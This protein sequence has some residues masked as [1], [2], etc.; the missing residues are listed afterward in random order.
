MTKISKILTAAAALGVMGVAVLPV[1]AGAST[2]TLAVTIQDSCELGNDGAI[3]GTPG[4]LTINT[5]TASNL[6]ASVSSAAGSKMAVVCNSGWTLTEQA[7]QRT[8]DTGDTTNFTD[9]DIDDAPG[10]GITDSF[11]PTSVGGTDPS[12]FGPN[13]YG[14]RYTA[15]GS[16]ATI[17]TA[18]AAYHGL[19]AA[20][21]TITTA[22]GTATGD[23]TAT[24]NFGAKWDGSLAGGT[25][26]TDVEWT[27]TALPQVEQIITSLTV[28]NLLADTP[29]NKTEGYLIFVGFNY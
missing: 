29:L 14:V 18:A 4:G 21:T 15:V 11:V 7:A 27:L 25:Y 6:S 17:S 10:T 1:A 16:G 20:A 22:N 28:N 12:L 13:E 26:Q 5:L 2:A 24:V 23:F 19:P 9:L 8:G 3:T